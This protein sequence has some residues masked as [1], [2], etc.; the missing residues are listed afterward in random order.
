[1]AEDTCELQVGRKYESWDL[2][3]KA[4]KDFQSYQNSCQL[5]PYI[6]KDKIMRKIIL[7]NIHN[8]WKRNVYKTYFLP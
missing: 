1:M 5:N 8:L 2:A 3:K 7:I 4:I 6:T